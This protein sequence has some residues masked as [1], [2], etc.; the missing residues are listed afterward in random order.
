MSESRV[1]KFRKLFGQQ[2][3]LDEKLFN[4]FS[5]AYHAEILLQGYLYVSQNYFSFYSNV[6]GYVTKLVI[7]IG[8]V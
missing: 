1:K 8:T 4:Y 6:F 7:P 5:C 3:A 2:V